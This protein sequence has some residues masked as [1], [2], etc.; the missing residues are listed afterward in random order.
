M[1]LDPATPFVLLDDARPGGA[2][3]LYRAP[4]EVI[5]ADRADEVESALAA[6][7]DTGGRHAAGF[8]AYEAGLA[9]EPRLASLRRDAGAEPLVWFG[10]F[11]VCESVAEAASLLPDP[12]GAWVGKPEPEV[13]RQ[14][15]DVAITRVQEWIA[16]G[17]IYQANVTFRAAVRT[18]GHPL[19]LYAAIRERAAAGWGGIVWTGEDWLLSFSPES[20]FR[21][22]R[23]EIAARPMKGT[24]R[25]GA[26]PE[27]DARLAAELVSDEKQR[28]ENLMIVDLMR[29]DLT[30]VAAPGSVNVPELFV[31][32]TYPTVHQMISSVTATLAEDIG[33]AEVLARL[34]PCG[35]VT[36]APKIRAMEVIAAV[37][38][39][40]RGAYTGSIGS[41]SP[42][43]DAAFNVAIR[44][45]HMT[46]GATS[47]TIGLGSGVVADSRAA[48]EWDECHAKGDFLTA[49]PRT[50]DLIETMAFDPATGLRLLER[51]LA[52]MKASADAFGVHFDRH[53]VR[54]ELQAATF[55]L[56]AARKVR[57]LLAPTGVIAIEI[58][59]MPDLAE[60]IEVALVPLPV[61]P[62][63]Y[64]LRHKTTDRAFY[65]EARRASGADEVAFILPD[66][67]LTE[68]SFTNIFVERGGV[69]VTPPLGNLLPGV[70]RAELLASGR[71]IEGDL[72]VADLSGGFF[73]GNAVR[74]LVPAVAVAS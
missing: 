38:P 33:P 1:R 16:A 29:N 61:D 28:A 34:F 6:L 46:P 56:R 23:G 18:L 43:G 5:R 8:V 55:R 74:G 22:D 30:R 54:N 64:R 37:E 3:R 41:I 20:F 15:Y 26:T 21:I 35:S 11:D 52:R 58:G 31:V 32:E 17:D 70:L 49:G 40:P 66:G 39:D 59:P 60:P 27:E 7:A 69:L 68:G 45:L 19:A 63:D 12:R 62:R 51:H 14:D 24:A 48:E 13:T 2:A 47:A 25:R 10:L 42:D 50:P 73:V 57:L 36:G 44:T 9:L 53:N 4:V 71:A 72:T 65:D 67:R